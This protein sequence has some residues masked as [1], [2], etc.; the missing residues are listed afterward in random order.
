MKTNII[1][2]TSFNFS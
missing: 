2:D 1:F